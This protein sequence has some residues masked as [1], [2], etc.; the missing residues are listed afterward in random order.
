MDVE[1]PLIL[2]R[3]SICV[4]WWDWRTFLCIN[5]WEGEGVFT[6]A[7][8]CLI[9]C[10]WIHHD[11]LWHC[12][13]TKSPPSRFLAAS[14]PWRCGISLRQEI[15]L[16]LPSHQVKVLYCPQCVQCTLV[17]GWVLG[18]LVTACDIKTLVSSV[19]K[20]R[21]TVTSKIRRILTTM[22]NELLDLWTL[23]VARTSK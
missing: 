9:S 18:C 23:F 2:S 19:S 5:V 4:E 7:L 16:C 20:D 3:I 6:A 1:A 22:H 14:V 15:L 17:L 11:R 8:C 12:L 13:M 10:V 21:Q